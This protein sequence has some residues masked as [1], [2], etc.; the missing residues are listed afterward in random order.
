MEPNNIYILISVLALVLIG[1]VLFI[2]QKSTKKKV[3]TPLTSLAYAFVLAGILFGE[4]RFL[5]Y[6]LLGIGV[7]LSIIDIIRNIRLENSSKK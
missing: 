3:I 6:S 5:G 7:L 2:K 1:L 4:E